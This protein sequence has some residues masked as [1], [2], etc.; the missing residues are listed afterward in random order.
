[1]LTPPP[2]K[3]E[4]Q[5]YIVGS[6]SL[7]KWQNSAYYDGAFKIGRD[8]L[9]TNRNNLRYVAKKICN[10]P[11]KIGTIFAIRGHFVFTTYRTFSN[12]FIEY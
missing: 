7:Q 4:K 9:W 1:M 3:K 5:D 10:G 8:V 6:V 11:M 2:K 12:I